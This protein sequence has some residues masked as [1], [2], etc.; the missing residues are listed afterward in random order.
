MISMEN[1]LDDQ[2]NLTQMD[3]ISVIGLL[4][5]LKNLDLNLSQDDFQKVTS[6]IYTDVQNHLREQDRK[7][8][9]IISLLEDKNGKATDI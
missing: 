5:S 3:I 7:M 9:Y 2:N 8:D 6:K 4:I 1:I